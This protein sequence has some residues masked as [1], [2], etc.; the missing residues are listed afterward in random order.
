MNTACSQEAG[1]QSGHGTVSRTNSM[2][3]SHLWR[4]QR[5]LEL[6]GHHLVSGY[7]HTLAIGTTTYITV[8]PLV[9]TSSNQALQ[10]F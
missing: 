6:Q 8:A 2:H 9:I 4:F 10:Q 7:L 1:G 3:G 5:R